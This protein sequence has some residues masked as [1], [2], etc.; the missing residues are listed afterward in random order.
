MTEAP[1]C[2]DGQGGAFF[3]MSISTHIATQFGKLKTLMGVTVTYDGADFTAVDGVAFTQANP[4]EEGY[5]SPANRTIYVAEADLTA[6]SK[7][8]VAGKIMTIGSTEYRIED[9]SSE[10]FGVF[11][12]FDLVAKYE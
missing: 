7:A 11:R 3:V 8:P 2:S 6:E 4:T 1:P 10:P 9:I 5:L 12:R